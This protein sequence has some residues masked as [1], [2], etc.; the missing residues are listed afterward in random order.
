MIINKK[1]KAY[2]TR[3][4]VARIN[5]LG[6]EWYLVPDNTP[7]AQK[8]QKLFPRFDFVL[9]DKGELIDVVEIPKTEKEIKIEQIEE[10][11]LALE[12]LDKIINRATED[13]YSATNTIP[14]T[15]VQE[16]I[17]HKEKLRREL[18]ELNKEE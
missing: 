2:Q 7:L 18:Q 5:W 15:N 6:D 3:S 12:E 4:D 16:A 8:V 17:E 9:D 10:I 1:T 13:L 14:H 11:H